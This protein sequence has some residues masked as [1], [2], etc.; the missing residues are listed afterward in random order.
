M[1]TRASSAKASRRASIKNMLAGRTHV[2]EKLAGQ[3]ERWEACKAAVAEAE[4]AAVVE[5]AAARE[6]YQDALDAGWT[7][8]ELAAAGLKPPAPPRKS[9]TPNKSARESAKGVS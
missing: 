9:G 8:S 6:V 7:A 5:A 1:T 3:L 2:A 4:Q